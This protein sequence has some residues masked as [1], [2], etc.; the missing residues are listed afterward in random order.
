M[1][2][3]NRKQFIQDFS[4]ATI[5]VND[6]SQ[7]TKQKL[8]K[9]GIS[10]KDIVEVAGKD[11]QIS[12]ENDL[13]KLF[14][15]VDKTD[16][17]GSRKSFAT[18]K[19]GA[20][21]KSGAAYEALKSE[22]DRNVAKARSQ[23]II[24]LGMREQSTLEADALAKGNPAANGGVVRIEAFRSKGVM[25]YEGKS[26][27]LKSQ[28][29]LNDFR[30]ALTGAPDKMPK[31]QAQ[32]FIDTLATQ[33]KETRDELAQL[34]LSLYRAGE[35]K[36][37][38]NRLV[39]SGHGEPTGVISGESMEEEFSLVDVDK[40]AKVFPKG[41]EKIEHVAVAACFCA[42][43]A[44][45]E[46]LQEAFPKLQSAFAYRDFSPKAEKGAPAHLAK[47]ESMTDGEDASK[48]DPPYQKTATWNVK[49]GIQGLPLRPLEQVEKFAKRLSSA[50]EPYRTGK[51]DPKLAQRDRDLDMYYVALAELV[52]H[53]DI[54]A[55]RKKEV[56]AIRKEVLNLRHPR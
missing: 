8:E 39:L 21:T 35:G 52:R 56:E 3:I 15:L 9:A 40:L 38:V 28:T 45:F 46:M 47:W 41:A 23:G 51:M 1:S 4:N 6:M 25:A 7:E 26:F 31:A 42:G 12:G 24:H 49:D 14:A 19:E 50:Y 43:S 53:P 34:G 10:Q 17:D 55:E 48:I 30:D 29:G 13:K 22:F 33:N 32:K 18:D 36:L 37:P 27:D 2:T 16:R 20:Q 44:N 5:N 54:S 11:G